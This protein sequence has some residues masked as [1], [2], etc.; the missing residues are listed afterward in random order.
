[1]LGDGCSNQPIQ[2]RQ[3]RAPI[4]PRARS[5]W[6]LPVALATHVPIAPLQPMARPQFLDAIYQ[7]PRRR[8]V[9]QREEAVEARETQGA[10]DFRVHENRFQ[11][12]AEIKIAA[13]ARDV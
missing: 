2:L 7:R 9:I 3:C 4:L 12:R 13:S 8:N 5:Q 6:K 11:L 10:L 1:M